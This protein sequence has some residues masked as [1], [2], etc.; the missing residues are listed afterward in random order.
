MNF[1]LFNEKSKILINDSQNKTISMNHQ[2]V[3]VE[4]FLI[5]FFNMNDNY[6]DDVFKDLNINIDKL[7]NDI[8][9]ILKTKPSIVGKNL[10]IYFSEDLVNVFKDSLLSMSEFN[11]QY[12]SPEIIF[13]AILN[14]NNLEIFDL[15]I[16]YGLNKEDFKKSLLKNRK[17]Q[18]IDTNTKSIENKSLKKFS[19]DMTEL[20][21]NGRLD[22]VIGREEEIRR[23]IQVLSRR[24]KNNPVLIGEPG[25][26]KT[27]IV[28]GL[29]LRIVNNDVPDS[30]KNKKLL[31]LDIGSI[32]AGAKFRGEF[33]ERLKSILKEVYD[34]QNSLILFID[35][36]HTL[37]GAGKTD[38]A[39]DAS[40]LLKPALARGELHCI[41]ATTLNEYR[42]NIEADAALARRF[43]QIL[44]E[45]PT[46]ND[47]ISILRGLKE[48]YEVHHGVK[49]LDSAI[50]SAVEL[51]DRYINDRFLP[52]KAIDLMDE[53]A[54]RIRLQIDS[55]PEELDKIQRKLLQNKI[56]YESLKKENDKKSQERSNDLKKEIE[57]LEN[58]YETFNQK[59][60]NEKE[61]IIEIQ[62][63]KSEIDF[64]KNQ[65]S[66]L[67]RE[68]K[69][70]EAGELAYSKIPSLNKK[71][72]KFEESK[73]EKKILS[74]SVTS[75]EIAQ[76]ISKSTG[77]PVDKM[78]EEEKSKLLNMNQDLQKRVI[79]QNEAIDKISKAVM[80]ARAGIQDPNRPIGIF[81]FLGP[82]GVGKT[83]LT[84]ALSY[85]LFN[86]KQSFFR[87]DMS[88]YMEKHSVS[89]LIGAPPGYIGYESGGIL[90]ES[91]RRKP[92]QIIL[93]DEIEK[94]HPDIFNILLQVFDDGRLTDSNGRT[95]NFK[96]TLIVMT[97]NIGAKL[98][99][100]SENQKSKIEIFTQEKIFEEVRSFFKPEF[101]NR[102][103][104]IIIFNRLSKN[105][106]RKIL[107]LQ[108]SEI[109]YILKA[110]KINILI[111]ESAENWLIDEGFS[112]SYG[113]RPLKRIIQ[114]NIIDKITDMILRNELSD[115]KKVI[116][117]AENNELKFKTK[118]EK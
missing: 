66:I 24:T 100:F 64:Q 16:N 15:L 48:K 87:L 101:I 7:K 77:V 112:E 54:S 68:G 88:E 41:G 42:E 11:D 28:E 98:I 72:E 63:L 37:V 40:N 59:W 29:A 45:E 80:R 116:I 4:H 94:A 117:S 18:V 81:L 13:Y 43:Q 96:N 83:E 46:V 34:N 92:Y 5:S 50:V 90:T 27:A 39:M 26:G 3:T 95:V 62:K 61:K 79:G 67:Q 21:K 97:S 30:L 93:L 47:S 53:A 71:L 23:S 19:I 33:E 17:G 20:A 55:K 102:I 74:K 10:N 89:K 9:K 38:G 73:E 105:E 85:F 70:S 49:I 36:I 84:K 1:E 78:L 113:A 104:D 115:E 8:F 76:V 2:Q 110:K 58:D 75:S 91:V 65:L 99:E 12:V 14:Q 69:L 57:K 51:S 25:V 106:I 52:D 111:E 60:I 103:D 109:I 35:E 118:N 44:V 86:E 32:L 31:S 114:N 6:L 22:P 108:I 56:E 107:K 82:T